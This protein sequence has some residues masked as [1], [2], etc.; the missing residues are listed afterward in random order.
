M[1]LA[2]QRK[3]VDGDRAMN[4]ATIP[5]VS[6]GNPSFSMKGITPGYGPSL[7]PLFFRL[8]LVS[9][10]R[11]EC[12]LAIDAPVGVRAE[13]I[14]LTLNQC[15]RQSVGTHRVEVGQARREHGGRNAVRRCQCHN[16][17]Q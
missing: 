15:C 5:L 3:H 14:T 7:V 1:S 6:H 13:E 11:V 10:P 4:R 9:P 8:A 2:L 17:A 16:L 12:S